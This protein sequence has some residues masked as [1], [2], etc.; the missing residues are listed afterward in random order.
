MR[1]QTYRVIEPGIVECP[2]D[3]ARTW[4]ALRNERL[5]FKLTVYYWSPE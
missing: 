3:D 5:L 1:T 2:S 4:S